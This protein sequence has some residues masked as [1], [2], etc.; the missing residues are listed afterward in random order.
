MSDSDGYDE[1][2]S[3]ASD[4]ESKEPEYSKGNKRFYVMFEGFPSELDEM[5]VKERVYLL[6]DDLDFANDFTEEFHQS[7]VRFVLKIDE[8]EMKGYFSEPMME[9]KSC[10]EGEDF[11]DMGLLTKETSVPTCI[12][13]AYYEVD[14]HEDNRWIEE[15][16]GKQK[17]VASIKMIPGMEYMIAVEK[18]QQKK[19]HDK[20]NTGLVFQKE[21]IYED[22]EECPACGRH[23]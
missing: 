3:D 19:A 17:M 13:Y 21:Y 4:E 7:K 14:L 2:V 5:F 6:G 16:A 23:I 9:R 10:L 12:G 15:V 20:M 18:I 22:E 8:S 11:Y 1:D